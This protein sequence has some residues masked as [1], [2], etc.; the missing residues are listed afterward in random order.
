[1]LGAAYGFV[2]TVGA[3]RIS[4]GTQ[5]ARPGLSRDLFFEGGRLGLLER[6]RSFDLGEVQTPP[7]DGDPVIM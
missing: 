2:C 3:V 6:R 5:E 1:M 7:V 4:V